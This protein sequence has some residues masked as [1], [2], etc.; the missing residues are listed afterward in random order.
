MHEWRDEW[1][2]MVGMEIGGWEMRGDI[3]GIGGIGKGR[4]NVRAGSGEPL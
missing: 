2:E 3:G 4:R 1:M